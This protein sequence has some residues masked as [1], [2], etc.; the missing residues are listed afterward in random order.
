MVFS[1]PFTTY[2]IIFHS[3]SSLFGVTKLSSFGASFHILF[4]FFKSF[5]ER[6]GDE[7]IIGVLISNKF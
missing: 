6:I 2:A 7:V 1:G 4:Q 5:V 3:G